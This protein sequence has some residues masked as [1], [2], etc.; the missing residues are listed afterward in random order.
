M[1]HLCECVF[2]C[3]WVFP[4]NYHKA[5][6]FISTHTYNLYT[7]RDRVKSGVF[8]SFNK[9]MYLM[10]RV[11]VYWQEEDT[12]YLK[13]ETL[14]Q[15]TRGDVCLRWWLWWVY[16]EVLQ[17]FT[18]NPWSWYSTCQYFVCLQKQP[19]LIS[20]LLHE[21]FICFCVFM[22]RNMCICGW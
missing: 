6:I 20:C 19:L 13:F 7:Q 22:L 11:C 12:R 5:S 3:E 18:Q 15:E 8:I 14:R 17:R 10:I 9:Y 16:E 21:Y 2:V 1:P 4:L